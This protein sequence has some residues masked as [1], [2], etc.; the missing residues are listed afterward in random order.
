MKSVVIWPFRVATAE[1]VVAT[2]WMTVEKGAAVPLPE[3]LVGLDFGTALE[4]RRT[5][6]IDIDGLRADCGLP[7]SAELA[8]AISWH[9]A[10]TALRRPMFNTLLSSGSGPVDVE[11]AG[12]VPTDAIAQHLALHTKVM[13]ARPLTYDDRTVARHAGSAFWEDLYKVTLDPVTSLFPVELVDLPSSGWAEPNAGW[14]LSWSTFDLDRPFLGSVRLFINS[15]HTEVAR[16]VIGPA[17][18][19][20]AW[21]MRQAIYFDVA[22]ALVLGVLHDSDFMQRRGEYPADSVGRVVRDIIGR[23]WPSEELSGLKNLA[24]SS[25]EH[26][27]AELQARLEIFRD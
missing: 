26:F 3:S 18:T 13:L 12:E 8:L 10:G 25:P 11:V 7:A 14:F 2:P 22:R 16:A 27:N 19:R 24:E 21:I 23:L 17:L 4:V 20:D 5:V 6:R 9:S 15:K 1:R